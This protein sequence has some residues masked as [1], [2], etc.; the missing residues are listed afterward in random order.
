MIALL[1]ALQVFTP[2]P[3]STRTAGTLMAGI[4]ISCP[5]PDGDYGERA[6]V[7]THTDGGAP[8]LEFHMGPRDEFAIFGGAIAAE[9]HIDHTSDRNLLAGYHFGDLTTVFG[10]RTWNIPRLGVKLNVVQMPG[11]YD[12]CY[13]F[14]LKL[15]RTT[16]PKWA[17]R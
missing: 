10:G 5:Q 7:F 3:L 9:E 4:W 12:D 11:S 1:L 2:S 16:V 8:W 17:R 13:Y 6:M 15:E 14:A